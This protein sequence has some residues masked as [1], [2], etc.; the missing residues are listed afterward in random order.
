MGIVHWFLSF[1][2][3]F[4][5]NP[6]MRRSAVVE[7]NCFVPKSCKISERAKIVEGAIL[8]ENI[9]IGDD[10]VLAGEV[11]VGDYCRI[12]SKVHISSCNDLGKEPMR[13]DDGHGHLKVEDEKPIEIGHHTLII[14]NS[15]VSKGVKIGNYALIK[16]G[17]VV[18]EDVPDYAI[19]EGNPAKVVGYREKK[20]EIG[21]GAKKK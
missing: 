19:V 3:N 5:S 1:T 20:S 17:S 10:S 18:T 11:T 6:N 12:A 15:C 7:K 9:S 16:L 2:N 8:G 14:A 13:F 21:G 4:R